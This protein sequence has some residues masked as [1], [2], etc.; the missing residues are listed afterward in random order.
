MRFLCPF[1]LSGLLFGSIVSASAQDRDPLSKLPPP[2]SIKLS[3]VIAEVERRPG[4]FGIESISFAEGEYRVVYFMADGAEV[5][6]NYDAKTGASRPPR[7]GL[8]GN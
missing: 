4:F 6:I 5:R 2:D 8:F 1:L 7:R 3:A